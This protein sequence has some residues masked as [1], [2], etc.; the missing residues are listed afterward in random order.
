MCIRYLKG[1][2]ST[3]LRV[4]QDPVGRQSN[5]FKVYKLT[6]DMAL[7]PHNVAIYLIKNKH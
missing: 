7:Q 2:C 1:A 6:G 5:V 3:A 4:S